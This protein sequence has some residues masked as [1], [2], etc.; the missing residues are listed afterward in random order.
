MPDGI[1]DDARVSGGNVYDR[2]F[3]EALRARR[4]DIR[5]VRV[6]EGSPRDVA[7]AL[8]G[9]P[10]DALVLVD[11][12]L[13]VAASR[14]LVAHATRLRIVVL[15]H[16]V[17]SAMPGLERAA[18]ARI[19]EREREALHAAR[20]VIAT[21]E[22]TRSELLARGLASS[23]DIVVARP[24]IDAVPAATGSTSGGHLL[25]V[26]AVAPHKGQDVLVHALAGMADLPGWTCSIVG[27]LDLDPGYAT[28]LADSIRSAGLADRVALTGVL[29]G[30]RLAAAYDGADL[31]VAPS[32]AESYGMAVAEAVARGIPV[33]ASRVGGLTE[34]TEGSTA[35]IL[36]P[37]NDPVSLRLPLRMWWSEPPRRAVLK[38]EAMR[39]RRTMPRR[40][41]DDAA[42]VAAAALVG[43][44]P[45]SGAP[46]HER[47]SAG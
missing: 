29:T 8:S 17:A 19:A 9:L 28:R 35:A 43:I 13:A 41:W 16:M 32:R 25:C 1:D 4:L 36:V 33:V 21:S 10:H 38:A 47:R 14:V 42:Q 18:R 31:F 26:G 2:R 24:G 7:I 3:G 5:M 23:A 44:A 37:A 39:S 11:G 22:S 45:A 40:A 15:A 34:A 12:L 30:E 46:E 27:S 20:R 6:A